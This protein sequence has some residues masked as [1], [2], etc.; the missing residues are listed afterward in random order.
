MTEQDFLMIEKEL[1]ITLPERYKKEAREA[2]LRNTRYSNALWDDPKK[3]IKT[4][5]R[6]RKNG[7]YGS[8]PLRNYHLVIGFIF[9]HYA[10]INVSSDEDIQYQTDRTK[11]WRY[12]P[13]DSSTAGNTM[14]CT[15][16]SYVEHYM[17]FHR[18]DEKRKQ[19]PSPQYTEE[20]KK[21][22]MIDF[23]S[24]I[25]QAMESNKNKHG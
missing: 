25:N 10:Y 19:N 13:D 17:D 15:L 22:M 12:A 8:E 16:H 5:L 11:T 23:F 2:V 14:M 3:I 21:Q 6:L 18:S 4:N 20:E 1:D 9:D 7:I 24:Q